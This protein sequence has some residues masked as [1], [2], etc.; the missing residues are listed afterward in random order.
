MSGGQ[1]AGKDV[2]DGRE[3]T[4]TNHHL[5]LCTMLLQHENAYASL[6]G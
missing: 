6:Q 3:N 2:K 1:N 5:C 4:L